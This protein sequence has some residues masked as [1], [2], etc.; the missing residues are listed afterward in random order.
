MCDVVSF[1]NATAI[2]NNSKK[3]IEIVCCAYT[4]FNQSKEFGNTFTFLTLFYQRL[5]CGKFN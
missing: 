1:L 2:C 3:Y 4:F 5:K